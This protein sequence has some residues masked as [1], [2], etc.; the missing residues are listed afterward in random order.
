MK[1]GDLF[2]ALGFQVD[3]KKLKGFNDNIKDGTKFLGSMS[4]AAGAAVYAV[5]NFT[6]SSTD[7]AV[8]LQN[9]QTQ[10]GI[11][12]DD[13][14]RFYSVA[15]G[16]N[17]E[18]SLDDTIDAFRNLRKSVADAGLGNGPTGEAGLLG[19]SNF[20]KM[21]PKQIIDQLRATY[22]Q[23]LATTGGNDPVRVQKWMEA[24]GLGPQFFQAITASKE[25]YNELYDTPILDGD[26]QEKLVQ[27]AIATKKFSNEWELMKGTLSGDFSPK[28]INFLENVNAVM[29]KT[30]ELSGKV[31]EN[32]GKLQEQ[33]DPEGT[34][35]RTAGNA[36]SAAIGWR[37][38]K[39]PNKYAKG[40][41]AAILGATAINDVGAYINGKPSSTG[42]AMKYGKTFAQEVI[43]EMQK[44]KSQQEDD[45]QRMLHDQPVN[46]GG[47][48]R[49]SAPGPQSM[50]NTF[51]IYGGN[52][53]RATAVAVV[54]RIDLR[55]FREAEI[56]LGMTSSGAVAS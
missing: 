42:D 53:A 56:N 21:T 10:T 5:K 1:V 37:L 16:L 12:T 22:P 32:I 31:S 43:E 29:Q 30:S 20:A 44:S 13:V 15:S 45:R 24:I 26:A 34:I 28:I 41:G 14:R 35:S 2:I 17:A 9:L 39:S 4:A 8:K 55:S 36:T 25:K 47:F 50:N 51:N 19:L 11:A 48:G 3:D 27:L 7:A 6:A 33:H 52:D 54:E 49:I 46:S 18:I 38:L 40:V 23:I